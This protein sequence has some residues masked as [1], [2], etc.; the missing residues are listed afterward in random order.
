[1]GGGGWAVR[2]EA[3]RIHGHLPDAATARWVRDLYELDVRATDPRWNEVGGKQV[4]GFRDCRN[5]RS[6]GSHCAGIV[7]YREPVSRAGQR[8]P[9][10]DKHFADRSTSRPVPAD[11]TTSSSGKQSVC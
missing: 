3:G 7:E 9:L 6:R 5:N 8:V 10:C 11:R 2:F 4:L 1:M